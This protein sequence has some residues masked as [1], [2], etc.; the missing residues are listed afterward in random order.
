MSLQLVANHLA[1]KGRGPDST[2]V[3]MSNREVA[4]LQALAKRHGGELS[5]NPDTGLPEAGFLDSLLP[6]IAGAGLTYFSGGAITP[7]MAAGIVG[8]I[9]ALDSK[10]L[11]KG[12]M[13]GLGAWGGGSMVGGLA[14][15]GLE[16]GAATATAPASEA[17]MAAIKD[18]AYKKAVGEGASKFGSMFAS[19][20]M[21]TIAS[22]GG[23]S[24]LNAARNIFAA[25]APAIM[26]D[27]NVKTT[28]PA[29][30][31]GKIR[32][33]TFNAQQ[34]NPSQT[35]PVSGER[36]YFNNEFTAGDPYSAAN[37]GLVALARGG[38]MRRR[39]GYEQQSLFTPTTP[40]PANN[41]YG[42][43]RDAYDYL[44]GVNPTSGG[45]PY[46]PN[47]P[48]PPGMRPEIPENGMQPNPNTPKTG[49]GR[50]EFDPVTKQ[51][52]WI[53]DP[54]TPV[55]ATLPVFE[56]PE[57]G[58]GGNRGGGDEASESRYNPTSPMAGTESGSLGFQ[59]LDAYG[60]VPFLPGSSVASLVSQNMLTGELE[61]AGK[62]A[63]KA[64]ADARAGYAAGTM[65]GAPPSDPSTFAG[66][67]Y[68]IPGTM[69][70]ATGAGFPANPMSV[71]PAQAGQARAT[72]E[73]VT[74]IDAMRAEAERKEAEAANIRDMLASQVDIGNAM[75][76]ALDS[77]ALSQQTGLAGLSMQQAIDSQNASISA[78][79]PT[80]TGGIANGDSGIGSPFSGGDM[81]AGAL[82]GGIGAPPSGETT[83]SN[84]LMDAFSNLGANASLL[85]P[86][87]DAQNFQASL[88]NGITSDAGFGTSDSGLGGGAFP[89]GSGAPPSGGEGGGAFPGDGGAPPSG[90]DFGYSASD[91]NDSVGRS[92]ND[93]GG[94]NQGG[95]EGG[96]YSN[97]SDRG[98]AR[99]GYL[100]HGRFDQRMAHGGIAN[101]HQ[102]NLGSYSDGGRLL[103]GPGDGVS[104]DIPATIGR[105]QPARLADGE[106]VIP[107][108]IVSELG[109]GSTDAGAREL[110]KMMD[111]I[112]AGRRKTVGKKQVAKNS[113]AA[114][115]LP[116]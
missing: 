77:Q 38:D 15:M 71:D 10:D 113:K 94:G 36:R 49:K 43:S 14:G 27:Q 23:G 93:S 116:A 37:G 9:S 39:R 26:A 31:R 110:Y 12:L 65:F 35:G 48:F 51:Y 32:P 89:G 87:E 34:M 54:I 104:D 53:P 20:P 101:L 66:A 59:F 56:A 55:D 57:R 29:P 78:S 24:G 28:T 61:Q 67:G 107:A 64:E 42:A 85:G 41:M 100:Q 4:G 47:R 21:D 44:M 98:D 82:P 73:G 3:H 88:N 92:D 81:G 97:D 5:V 18:D 74:A 111:R 99:G 84:A 11:G 22:F 109:N 75:Q 86:A 91:N 1:Q 68:G 16:T 58:G 50:Y 76:R 105:G 40:L 62:N 72:I 2:L 115:H 17:A 8:G 30:E 63:A 102:Y 46:D 112:Q 103:K 108:R 7:M 114:R 106:F 6:T 80:A 90:G 79:S 69:T 33:Y 45:Q 13:A 52:K 25:A 70:T 83:F 96:G 95:G 19:K 60:R